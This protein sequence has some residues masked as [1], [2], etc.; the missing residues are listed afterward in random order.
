MTHYFL[1]SRIDEY[2]SAIEIAQIKRLHLFTA[3]KVP[4]KIVT[5]NHI[6]GSNRVLQ[7]LIESHQVINLYQ[8]FTGSQTILSLIQRRRTFFST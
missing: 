3:L 2:T 8:Y 5:R 7:Q 6:R 1:T 4:A